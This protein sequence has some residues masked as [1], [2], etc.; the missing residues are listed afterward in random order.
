M[1]FAFLMIQVFYLVGE[2]IVYVIRIK[3]DFFFIAVARLRFASPRYANKLLVK[4]SITFNPY[5]T[6][7]YFLRETFLT[8]WYLM[9]N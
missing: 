4:K 2:K 6:I 1:R 8:I 3:S 5:N 7:Y 9:I